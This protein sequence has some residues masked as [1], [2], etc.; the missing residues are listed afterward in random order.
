MR[1]LY[2]QYSLQEMYAARRA[3][4]A[5][6]RIDSPAAGR[7]LLLI[8]ERHLL[9]LDSRPDFVV[10]IVPAAIWAFLHFSKAQRLASRLRR[11]RVRGAVADQ[12]VRR[13][14]MPKARRLGGGSDGGGRV[15]R[16]L[17]LV[18]ALVR[19]RVR[20]NRLEDAPVAAVHVGARRRPP[21]L[22]VELHH[23]MLEHSV[24]ACIT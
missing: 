3:L 7:K 22:P 18:L 17:G 16:V 10:V 12:V 1:M 11:S 4:D 24:D 21:V 9:A 23:L 13:G 8:A 14:A 6:P 20:M 5:A 19:K 15:A 2:I